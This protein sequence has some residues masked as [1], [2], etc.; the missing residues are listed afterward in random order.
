[1]SVGSNAKQA[2]LFLRTFYEDVQSLL[3]ACEQILAE[4]KWTPPASSKIAELSNSLNHSHRW[5]LDSAFRS[6]IKTDQAGGCEAIVLLILLNVSHFEDARV[7]GVRAHFPKLVTH[8][9][10]WNGWLNAQRVLDYLTT[11]PPTMEIPEAAF[12]EGTL[13][14]ASRARG[15][16]VPVDSL[17]DE[18]AARSLLIEPLLKQLDPA[19]SLP[20]RAV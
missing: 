2:I 17:I 14:D 1:M 20:Q 19:S 9:Q 8:E 5:V 10:I 15:I 11:A 3:V 6:F 16:L 4:Q 7:L 13:P 18:N 12:K